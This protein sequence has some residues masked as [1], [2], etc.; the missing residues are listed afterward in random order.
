MISEVASTQYKKN[1]L[2]DIE[3]DF[4]ENDDNRWVY[5][6]IQQ[7]GLVSQLSS[8]INNTSLHCKTLI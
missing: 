5:A 4:E 7:T 2:Q 1:L 8:F 6:G 3:V